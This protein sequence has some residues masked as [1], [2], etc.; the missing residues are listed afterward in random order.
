MGALLPFGGFTFVTF[1]V[2]VVLRYG[3][4]W[5]LLRARLFLLDCFVDRRR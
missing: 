5:E 1:F 4:D 2:I 3:G